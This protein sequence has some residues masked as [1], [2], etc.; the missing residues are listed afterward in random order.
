MPARLLPASSGKIIMM[1]AP[2]RLGPQKKS[3]FCGLVASCCSRKSN[4]VLKFSFRNALSTRSAMPLVIG[5][6]KKGTE[7]F[8]ISAL[9]FSKCPS[10]RTDKPKRRLTSHEECNDQERHDGTFRIM[11]IVS[12]PEPLLRLSTHLVLLPGQIP[13]W[14]HRLPEVVYQVLH[15]VSRLRDD[16]GLCHVRPLNTNDRRL[17]QWVHLFKLFR[18]KLVLF[19]LVDLQ[20]ILQ[21]ELFQEPCDPMRSRLIEPESGKKLACMFGGFTQSHK[22]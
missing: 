15:N 18:S 2:V 22:R 21:P 13:G 10:V 16:F 3:P 17:P 19:T 5:L 6:M 11:H 14:C 1:S 4:C 9:S 12:I 7:A 20:L 8:L